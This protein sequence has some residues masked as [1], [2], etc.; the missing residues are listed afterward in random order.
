MKL[1][2]G[3]A[4]VKS[5]STLPVPDIKA[6][7]DEATGTLTIQADF[8]VSPEIQAVV[9]ERYGKNTLRKDE[10]GNV[11]GQDNSGT[12]VSV[13]TVIGRAR[14][15]PI[16]LQ[17]ENGLLSLLDDASNQIYLDAKLSSKS[18]PEEDEVDEGEET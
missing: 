12:V 16:V 11:T 6:Q 4:K 18:G 13:S 8:N 5:T 14:R 10:K 17:T 2:T 1:T 3:T 7:M 15:I 9:S